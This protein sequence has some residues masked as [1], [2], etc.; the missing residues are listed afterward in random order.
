MSR[1]ATTLTVAHETTC[2]GMTVDPSMSGVH[3][4]AVEIIVATGAFHHGRA[5]CH[6]KKETVMVATTTVRAINT[7]IAAIEDRKSDSNEHHVK[8][9]GVTSA[10]PHAISRLRGE[11]R[12]LEKA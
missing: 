2:A 12:S 8:A 7:T 3:H 9:T 10:K 6:A 11:S 4:R 1:D 5:K